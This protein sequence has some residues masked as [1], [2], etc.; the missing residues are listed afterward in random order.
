MNV[1]RTFA[2]AIFGLALATGSAWAPAKVAASPPTLTAEEAPLGLFSERERNELAPFIE[3]GP[4]ALVEFNEGDALPAVIFATKIHATP[5]HVVDVIRR[6]ETYPTFMP[7]LDSVDV[8]SRYDS[9]IAYAWTWKTV[10]FTLTGR[11]IMTVFPP[12]AQKPDRGYRISIRSTG[13]DLGTGRMMWRVYP[14]GQNESL[15]VFSSRIDLR[16]A[17]WI[18]RQINHGQRSVNR[19]AN[20]ALAFAMLRGVTRQTEGQRPAV[21]NPT[22]LERPEVDVRKLA[23]FL[24]RGDLL[25]IDMRGDRLNQVASVGRMF[26]RYTK[27]RK[28]M[29]N[30][31]EFGSA[32][33][34]GSYVKVAHREDEV[35]DFRWGID[36]PLIGT[37]GTMR[38]KN[39]ESLITID[40]TKGAVKGGAWRFEPIKLPWKE[41]AMVSWGRFEPEKASWLVKMIVEGNKDL[42]DGIVIGSQLMVHRAIRTRSQS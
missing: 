19:T 24:N 2:L 41:G 35:T 28:V 32:L 5:E 16:K 31:E 37:S 7:A 20:I 14:S 13:G 21:T 42:G 4:V 22:E 36:I 30:P 27:V 15:V 17:N 39:G 18:T 8:E 11:N 9:M 6:P 10:L 1:H 3:R 29:D 12:P 25:L 26:A 40:A 23:A 33:I 38:M 34:P